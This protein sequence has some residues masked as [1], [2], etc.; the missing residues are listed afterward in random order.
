MSAL[1]PPRR[2]LALATLT[3]IWCGLWGE[4]TFANIVAG[5]GV[6]SGVIMLG[7]GT[8]GQGGIRP[9]PLLHLLW[10]VA[11]DLAKSTV[12]VATEIVTPTDYTDESIIAIDIG[13]E[14]RDHLLLLV[15]AIT[16]TPG[17]AVV[18]ADSDTGTLYLHLLHD[19]R[20]AATIE[21]VGQLAHLAARALPTTTPTTTTTTTTTTRT[22]QR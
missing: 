20:R 4:V 16:L 22:A 1:L 19:D 7:V 11:V 18:D 2:L 15:V 17:T 6:S 9:V 12:G 14:S 5:L 21:H 3:L 13:P 10:V 8:P